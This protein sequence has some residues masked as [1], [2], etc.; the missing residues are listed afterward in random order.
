MGSITRPVCIKCTFTPKMFRIYIDGGTNNNKHH[1]RIPI[2][3]I[4][5]TC[6]DVILNI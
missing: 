1:S 5:K 2:G 6:K 3:W 4:C